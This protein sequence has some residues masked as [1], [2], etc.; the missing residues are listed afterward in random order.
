LTFIHELAHV[1][2]F[3]RRVSDLEKQWG[4]PYRSGRHDARQAWRL[5]RPHGERWRLEFVRLAEDAIAQGLFPGNEQIVLA[6]ATAGATSLDDVTLDLRADP[7]IDAEE[8]CRLDEQQRERMAQA[9]LQTEEFKRQFKAGHVVHFD[10]GPRRG[11]ITGKLVRVNRKSCTVAAL[12]ANWHV[13]HGFLRPGEAPPDA[14]PAQRRAT[15]RDRFSRGDRVYFRSDGKRY[16]GL[17]TRVNQKTCTVQTPEGDWRVTFS[18]L[19]VLKQ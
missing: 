12:G 17:I 9:Q 13:P 11:T 1:S 18:L 19:R 3:R 7:R 10:G 5:E 8:L 16:E 2:D 4:R 15:P 14:R 6:A